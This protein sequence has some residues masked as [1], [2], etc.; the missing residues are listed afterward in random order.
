MPSH[1]GVFVSEA[2]DW[3]AKEVFHS[4]SEVEIPHTVSEIRGLMRRY[5]MSKQQQRRFIW[6]INEQESRDI[7]ALGISHM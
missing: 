3:T 4:N 2:I 6:G 1:V 7:I 5:I